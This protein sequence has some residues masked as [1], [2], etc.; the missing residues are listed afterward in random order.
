MRPCARTRC[1]GRWSITA[2]TTVRKCE[3]ILAA[4][5]LAFLAAAN[6]R[7]VIDR[8]VER[9]FAVPANASA[10]LDVET[11]YGAIKI[12]RGTGSAIHVVARETIEADSEAQ[13]DR[14]LRNLD[15]HI[16]DKTSPTS[17]T[18]TVRAAFRR[19]VH[20]TWEKWPPLGLSFEIE[21][22]ERCQLRLVSREGA[23]TVPAVQGDVEVRAQ[24]GETFLGAITGAA[25]VKSG[26]GN[27]IVTSCTGRL[28]IDAHAG[29][30][31]VGRLQ[32]SAQIDAVGGTI[33][34]QAS[35]GD[36]RIHG[37]GADVQVGFVYPIRGDADVRA[38][39]GDLQAS[40]ETGVEAKLDV[41]AST[42]GQVRVR[43]LELSYISGRPGDAHVTGTLG[44]SGPLLQLRAGGGNVRLRGVPAAR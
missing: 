17:E 15:L 25:T 7:A 38:S 22:P 34:V 24:N 11:F 32:S 16:T 21:I 2:A 29:N 20:W 5:C 10:S 42:F 1:G 40:F 44:R 23:I 3:R 28:V 18:V 36:L 41:H 37:D 35:H 12:T 33:E 26:V 4:L 27:V 6:T 13:A 31:S 43:E 8:A 19:T 14:E 30:V 39:G 9:A